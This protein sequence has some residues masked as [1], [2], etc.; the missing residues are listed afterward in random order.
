M[1]AFLAWFCAIPA[2]ESNTT[3][4]TLTVGSGAVLQDVVDRSIGC[5]LMGL[6]TMTGIPGYL[7]G[8]V[9]GNAGAYGHSIEELV[10]RVRAFDGANVIALRNEECGFSYRTSVFKQRKDWIILSADLEFHEHDPAEL[11]KD[12][13]R[14]SRRTRCEVSAHR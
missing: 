14:H 5:G 12:G 7:G 4:R 3:D 10:R 9:Y 11:A 6:E 2:Q 13:D 8:A 1:R